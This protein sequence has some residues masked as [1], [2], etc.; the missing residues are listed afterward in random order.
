[1]EGQFYR[2]Q[3]VYDNASVQLDNGTVVNLIGIKGSAQSREYLEKH[4]VGSE[5]KL[6]FDNS[7][8]EKQKDQTK[9]IAAYILVGDLEQDLLPCA[10]SE[11]L[12]LKLSEL[13]QG[14]YLRDS[15][16]IYKKY[17]DDWITYPPAENADRK[18]F[19]KEELIKKIEP[20][21]FMVIC[22]NA[23]GQGISQGTGF[24]IS[25]T[26]GITNHHVIKGAAKIVIETNKGEKIQVANLGSTNETFDFAVLE[27]DMMLNY[28]FL[29]ATKMKPTK[30][31]DV[32]VFGNPRGLKNTVSN[33]IIS[34]LRSDAGDEDVI[35]FTAAVSPG[36]SGGPLVNMFGEVIGIV[37]F[38]ANEC[39]NC[40]FAI[41]MIPI[42]GIVFGSG[43]K[44]SNSAY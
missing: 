7:N 16:E 15:L 37:T 1:M 28:P 27:F 39:E 9:K 32:L 12:M 38:K 31:E 30:G 41:S 22:Y 29:R 43:S 34:Q 42:T 25:Q 14:T 20:S 44:S 3:R 35:Q 2:V 19:P 36:N 11:I 21:V 10:N 4:V 18:K 13:Y 17:A 8:R 40:N 6:I 26:Q 33:G 24:F 5:I 23:A